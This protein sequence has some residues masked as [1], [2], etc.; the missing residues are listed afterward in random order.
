MKIALCV[1]IISSIPYTGRSKSADLSSL[2]ERGAAG[3]ARVRRQ[4]E[5]RIRGDK[6][7]LFGR[8]RGVVSPNILPPADL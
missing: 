8:L 4:A 7:V 2:D 3:C 5:S 6:A 1:L